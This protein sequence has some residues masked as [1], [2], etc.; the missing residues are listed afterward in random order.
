MRA[1]ILSLFVL[2]VLLPLLSIAS[3]SEGRFRVIVEIRDAKEPF[4]ATLKDAWGSYLG[5]LETEQGNKLRFEDVP[6]GDFGIRVEFRSGAHLWQSLRV[7][8]A[9]ANARKEVK[10][11]LRASDAILTVDSL[12]STSV[13]SAKELAIPE[14]SRERFA[15]AWD[16]MAVNNWAKARQLLEGCVKESP[17]FFDAWNNLGVVAR[18]QYDFVA[19]EQYFR[20][21]RHLKPDS[22]EANIN[23]SEI[24]SQK[25]EMDEAIRISRRAHQIRPEDPIADAQ[26]GAHLF[27]A[28]KYEECIPYLERA[29]ARDPKSYY[30][31]Q[32]SLA[33][34]Y[35]ALSKPDEA[36]HYVEDWLAHHETNP[37]R[38][39]VESKRRELLQ[40]VAQEAE[41][42]AQ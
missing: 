12:E 17:G 31:P 19:A 36:L 42:A 15:K 22:F 32:I 16:E 23:L 7:D 9:H 11:K 18:K 27:R 1:R 13:I 4:M 8:A 24:L 40:R 26:L 2:I 33:V 28:G 10:V 25:G 5:H 34:A 29:A 14:S 39:L 30:F 6:P 21:A 3:V 20:N 41:V 35:E 37:N 38:V